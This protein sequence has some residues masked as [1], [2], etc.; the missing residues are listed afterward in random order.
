MS[1]G[2]AVE[3]QDIREILRVADR[4]SAGSAVGAMPAVPMSHAA[5]ASEPAAPVASAPP[6][7]VVVAPTEPPPRPGTLREFKEISERTF[8]VEKLREYGWNISR[9]AEML[10]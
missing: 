1:R 2:D 10:D 6:A 5:A 8:L 3:A 9:T 7:A 4:A